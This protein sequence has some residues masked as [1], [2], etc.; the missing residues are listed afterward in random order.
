MQ[1]AHKKQMLSQFIFTTFQLSLRFT[2]CCVYRVPFTPT[3]PQKLSV[4][5]PRISVLT[6]NEASGNWRPLV[7]SLTWAETFSPETD[8]NVLLYPRCVMFSVLLSL[9]C[10][11]TQCQSP[12]VSYTYFTMNDLFPNW[13]NAMAVVKWWDLLFHDCMLGSGTGSVW[14]LCCIVKRHFGGGGEGVS[15]AQQV[16]TRR[17]RH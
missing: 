1:H 16:L 4:W 12:S 11:I 7:S 5:S 14:V 17:K 8:Q 9:R 15:P 2:P 13:R 6:Q 10:I 3:R